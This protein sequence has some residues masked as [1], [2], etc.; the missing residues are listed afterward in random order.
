MDSSIIE[1]RR[2]NARL[3]VANA[4]EYKQIMGNLNLPNP[5]MMDVAVPANRSCG[6]LQQQD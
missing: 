1:E 5:K 3:Q 6:N 4:L 2:H